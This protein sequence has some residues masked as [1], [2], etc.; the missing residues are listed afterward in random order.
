MVSSGSRNDSDASRPEPE[1]VRRADQGRGVETGEHLAPGRS[2]GVAIPIG[3]PGDEVCDT[4]R[5]RAAAAR[6]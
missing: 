6:K 2:G 3:Q 1:P 5:R 4:A